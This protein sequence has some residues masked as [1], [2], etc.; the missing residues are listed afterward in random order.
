[1][2]AHLYRRPKR[3]TKR[4]VQLLIAGAI[5]VLLA[6]TMY[7]IWCPKYDPLPPVNKISEMK[8]LYYE[9]EE[10]KKIEFRV[11]E[12]HWE[13]IFDALLPAQF[14]PWPPGLGDPW[15]ARHDA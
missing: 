2:K 3:M 9:G 14:D 1:M 6:I 4:R 5:L 8:A 10:F 7:S 15:S 12:E 13:K 11:P